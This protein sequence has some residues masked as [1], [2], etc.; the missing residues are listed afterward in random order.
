V[1]DNFIPRL[2][3]QDIFESIHKS[4]NVLLAFCLPCP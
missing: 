1:G 4:I 3:V 2:E